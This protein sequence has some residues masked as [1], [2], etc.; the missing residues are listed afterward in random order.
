MLRAAIVTAAL[1][2]VAVAAPVQAATT[3]VASRLDRPRGLAFAPDGT[4]YA[5]LVGHGATGPRTKRRC[6]REGCF[7][8]TGRIVRVGPGGAVS[9][10][11]TG[12]VSMLSGP[13]A[14]FVIGADQLTV[15]PDGRL[16][17]AITA[18]FNDGHSRPP[19]QVP[20]RVRAQVG[21][22]VTVRP[23]GRLALGP[24]LDAPELAFDADHEG[25]I[26]NPYG[27]A[28]LGDAIYVSDSAANTLLEIRGGAV[29]VIAVF[30]PVAPGVQ[31]VPAALTAG[32]D[33]ALYVGEFTGGGSTP[34][35]ARIWRVVPGQAPTVYA[36]G[37][38]NVTALAAA[39]DGSLYATEFGQ[40]S[41]GDVVRIAPDGTQ[42]RLGVG[43]LHEPGGVAVAPDGTVYVSNW[44]LSGA[45]REGSA[46]RL[47]HTGAILRL[48]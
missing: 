14:S 16:A 1:C 38:S 18:E 20:R 42:T 47:R 26:S 15:L 17:S 11:V 3:V 27:I 5:A 32:P 31:S 6:N 34:G 21:R 33:G 35:S 7:G 23:G 41:G 8:A 22:L 37:L 19:R 29:G 36:T 48:G 12:L 44:T 10:V 4:L 13:D 24:R 28:A 43:E 40:G 39:P 2:A 46:P 9:D 30:P 45:H 25:K